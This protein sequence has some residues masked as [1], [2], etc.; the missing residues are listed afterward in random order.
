MDSLTGTGSAGLQ[1]GFVLAVIL[2]AF[3]FADRLG[4]SGQLAQR[5]F[6]VVLGLA[7]TFVVISSTTAFHRPPEVPLEIA[8]EETPFGQEEEGLEALQATT[9][10]AARHSSEVRT[11]HTGVGLIFALAGFALLAR[12]RT[13]PL[14]LVLG[15]LFL[16][17]FGTPAQPGG[18]GGFLD[19]FSA[20]FSAALPGG[21]TAGPG[22]A[23][24]IAHFAV[25]LF[26]TAAL[27]ALGLRR[28]ETGTTT[29][30]S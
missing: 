22:Q 17:I 25:L 13:V 19:L 4:G 26:G 23:R 16:L 7:L 27:L 15:G 2:L 18:S 29:E 20:L 8:F 3:F 30:A 24:D 5:A 6:Q 21:G 14:G 28:W 9:T 10:E 1:S 12:L 11:I